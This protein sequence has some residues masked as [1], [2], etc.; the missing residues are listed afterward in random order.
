MITEENLRVRTLKSIKWVSLGILLP[1]FISPITS[2][3]LASILIPSDF[4]T[5]SICL[6]IVSFLTLIQ[7][8]GLSD[9]LLKNSKDPLVITLTAFWSNVMMACILYFI[10]AFF[11]PFIAEFYNNPLLTSYTRV[12][13]LNLIINSFGLIPSTLMRKE[14]KF[15][16]I[17]YI[18]FIPNIINALV[19]IPLALLNWGIWAII[20]A[21]LLQN[22]CT[23]SAYLYY[24]KLNIKFLFLYK[25]LFQMFHFGKFV[26]LEQLVE[27][28]YS[29]FDILILGYFLPFNEVGFYFLGKSWITLV[30]NILNSPINTIIYPALNKYKDDFKSLV[31]VFEKVEQRMF[32]LN[33]PVMTLICLGSELVINIFLPHRYLPLASVISILVIGEGL[34]RNFSMQRDIFKVINKPNIYPNAFLINLV[35]AII[36]MLFAAKFGLFIFCIVKTLNDLL[37]CV[38]QMIIIRNIKLFSLL[39]FWQV[40]KF[41]I[42]STLSMI[43]AWTFIQ[44]FAFFESQLFQFINL[45]VSLIVCG[46]VFIG[47]FHLLDKRLLREIYLDA[48]TALNK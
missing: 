2:I 47:T 17:F 30:F 36:S 6:T 34:V 38:I 35:V 12:L 27:F 20:V 42:L 22:F 16:S 45:I 46:T 13:G 21:S 44:N 9:F 33:V 5:V 4:G 19:I 43:L 24:S 41:T 10:L 31:N 48:K 39:N 40:S 29:N 8:L 7:G 37:Y 28:V 11:A 1:K 3:I 14:L 23:N 18:Q 26:V 25:E 15:E 32:F